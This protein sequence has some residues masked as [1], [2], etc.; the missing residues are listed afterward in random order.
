MESYFVSF[1]VTT[2]FDE[3]D[4]LIMFNWLNSENVRISGHKHP[5][6]VHMKKFEN[7]GIFPFEVDGY[8]DDF[9]FLI[10]K[11]FLVLSQE[12]TKNE[13][14]KIYKKLTS[15]DDLNLVLMP[16]EQDCNFRCVYCH[17]DHSKKSHMGNEELL[18]L[19]K[20]IERWSPKTFRVDYFGGEPLMN[21]NFIRNFNSRILYLS[22]HRG[23][24]FNSSSMTT[25]GYLLNVKLFQE[26]LNLKVTTYQI[27]LDGMPEFHDE[28]RPTVHG[29]STFEQIY[30]NLVAISKLPRDKYFF[31]IT[32]RMNFNNQSASL[33]KR[34]P[35]FK[36]LE[37]DFG[38]DKRFMFM[39]QMI[40]N[41]KEE[42][43][44]K[45]FYC[46]VNEGNQLQ[47]Q[48]EQELEEKG[49]NT[50]PMILFSNYGSNYCYSG[51]SNN[52]IAYP[53]NSY[54]KRGMLI[55]K[56]TLAV[57]KDINKVGHIDTN[58]ILHRSKQWTFWTSETLF[59]HKK[60]RECFFVLNCFSK[61]CAL[62]NYR[63]KNLIC[64]SYKS[65]EVETVKRIMLFIQNG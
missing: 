62:T 42:I 50:V 5:M 65:N 43:D 32:V 56:C 19:E 10:S 11:K 63:K 13:V 3:N 14:R 55:E 31:S 25:N 24:E 34:K 8:Y 60:C 21:S 6:Y 16:V 59:K 40:S 27:T 29:K 1:L 20:F 28:Y 52:V 9:E 23:F 15:L 46:T 35:F 17:E 61:S 26:L 36:R 48:I 38:G 39:V 12:E 53:I 7:E 64:P 37:K 57:N 22:K 49:I 2:F 47:E 44:E 4:D 58:G 51:N 45:K 33:E 18:I 54:I 30:K 41:W